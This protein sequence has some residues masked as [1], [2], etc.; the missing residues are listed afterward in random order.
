[1]NYKLKKWFFPRPLRNFLCSAR[2]FAI[3]LNILFDLHLNTTIDDN[4]L[5]ENTSHLPI[6]AKNIPKKYWGVIQLETESHREKMDKRKKTS[7]NFFAHLELV[8]EFFSSSVFFLRA[9]LAR[10][11]TRRFGYRKY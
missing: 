3:L 9:L 1:M 2:E 7:C 8:N 11:S 4:K 6:D 5:S 10:T